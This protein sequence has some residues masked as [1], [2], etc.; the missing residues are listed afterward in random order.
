MPFRRVIPHSDGAGVIESVGPGVEPARVGRRAWVFGAQS[1]RP[2]GT[3]AQLTVVPS[4]QA[5][6]LPDGVSD[7][8]GGV[9]ALAAQ[10]AAWGDATVIGTVRRGGDLPHLNPSAL[11]HAV[12]LDQPD[13]ADAVRTHAPG[14]VDR[15]VEVAFSDNV[16]LDAAVVKNQTV[17]AAYATHRD[18]PDFPFWPMLF[19]NSNHPS[20]GQRRLSGRGQAAGS[21]RPHHRRPRRGVVDRDRHPTA[22]RRHSRCSRPRRRWFPRS[23]SAQYPPLSSSI[24]HLY[25]IV[26]IYQ[27]VKTLEPSSQDIWIFRILTC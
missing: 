22:A 9:G 15:I 17:I 4:W 25:A 19:S 27:R 24:A 16:D 6:D 7:E 5:I 21:S 26:G 1:Y 10:L 3:A 11:A 14:G 23:R 20:A 18:R 13:A 8:V 12:A 2:F